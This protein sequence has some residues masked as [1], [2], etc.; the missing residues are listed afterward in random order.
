VSIQQ[1]APGQAYPETP[2]NE[3]NAALGQAFAFTPDA[4]NSTDLVLAFTRGTYNGSTLA[5]AT[6]SCTDNAEN[7]VVAARASGALSVS[8]GTTNWDNT[9]TYGR[10]GRA[11][12]DG[13]GLAEYADERWS[14]GGIFD[15][16]T[17]APTTQ[18]YDVHISRP[19]ALTDAE[20]VALILLPREVTF[21]ADG[22][23]LSDARALVAATGS[24]TIKIRR[25][26]GASWVD[27][28]DVAWSAAGTTGAITGS[29]YTAPAGTLLG[30][31]GPATA[32]AT[33]A[34]VAIVLVGTRGI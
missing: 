22:G 29:A 7:Y 9:T 28:F 33:L 8:T 4:A 19:G 3:N 30:V 11:T 31:F 15:R 16:S 25:R 5:D 13:G 2:I 18:P 1:I 14:D 27:V 10:V 20:T 21:A 23:A 17:G 6:V 34:D 32:D 26:D 12:Y 24:T